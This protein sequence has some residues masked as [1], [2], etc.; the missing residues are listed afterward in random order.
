MHHC[1]S[2][3]PYSRRASLLSSSLG[4]AGTEPT[5]SLHPRD[6]S[7]DISD[8]DRADG[9]GRMIAGVGADRGGALAPGLRL[10]DS[11]EVIMD[12]WAI[13]PSSEMF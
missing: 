3:T 12:L 11:M 8:R 1:A 6:T 9:E 4:P 7:E 2:D 10:V 5:L 13:L